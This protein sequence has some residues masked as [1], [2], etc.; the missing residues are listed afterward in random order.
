MSQIFSTVTPVC[1]MASRIFGTSPPGSIT[2]AFLE[3]SSQMMVQFCSNSVTG[4][5]IAPAFALASACVSFCSVMAPQCRFLPC[6]Q[7][8][9]FSPGPGNNRRHRHTAVPIRLLV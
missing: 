1:L 7:A 2:T 5:M 9:D 8:K 3:G 6:R 4:T